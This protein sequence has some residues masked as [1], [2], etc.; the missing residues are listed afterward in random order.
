[1]YWLVLSTWF[2]ASTYG[3]YPTETECRDAAKHEPWY[4]TARCIPVP[5]PKDHQH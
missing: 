5:K 3:Q 2:W 1:M 4:V